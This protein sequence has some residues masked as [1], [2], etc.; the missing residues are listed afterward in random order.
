[1]DRVDVIPE[2]DPDRSRAPPLER[3][4]IA[5]DCAISHGHGVRRVFGNPI[6]RGVCCEAVTKVVNKDEMRPGDFRDRSA[7]PELMR[8]APRGEQVADR[9]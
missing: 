3:R 1:M 8:A 9:V 4:Q 6:R 2:P 5:A 7:D